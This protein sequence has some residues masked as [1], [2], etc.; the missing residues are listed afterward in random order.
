MAL[1]LAKALLAFDEALV[2]ESQ[3]S[4]EVTPGRL[5]I[6]DSNFK[7]SWAI[8][9]GL[10]GKRSNSQIRWNGSMKRVAMG[11]EED[12]QILKN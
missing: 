8:H 6:K 5:T 10:K 4:L 2:R 12:S 11:S 9:T 1:R 3:F 7:T